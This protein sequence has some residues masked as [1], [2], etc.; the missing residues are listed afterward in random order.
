MRDYSILRWN[1]K[2]SDKLCTNVII[3][4]F[5]CGTHVV[6][7]LMLLRYSCCC[8]PHAVAVLMMLLYSCCCCTHVV[9]V[10]MLELYSCCYTVNYLTIFAMALQK[11]RFQPYSSDF[12]F[13][14]II[15]FPISLC[16]LRNFLE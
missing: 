3:Y 4:S 15:Y 2:D 8:C 11:K 6:A 14:L 5:Y 16:K 12:S 10:L 7:V 1:E 9:A 13:A